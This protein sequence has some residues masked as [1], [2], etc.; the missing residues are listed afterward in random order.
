MNKKGFRAFWIVGIGLFFLISSTHYFF[1]TISEADIFS[2]E[3]RYEG[4]D[5]PENLFLDKK[6][7]LDGPPTPFSPSFF[8]ENNRFVLFLGFALL[9]PLINPVHPLLRC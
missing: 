4:R 9:A 6:N 1:L 2:N 8:I 3:N 5:Y 7:P